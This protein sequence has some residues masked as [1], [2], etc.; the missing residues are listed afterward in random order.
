MISVRE[1]ANAFIFFSLKAGDEPCTNM[2]LNKLLYFAQGYALQRFGE[3]LFDAEFEA[4]DFGPVLPEVYHKYKYCGDNPIAAM[5]DG[6]SPDDLA[7]DIQGLL[8]DVSLV[9]EQYST[10]A[11]VGMSHK[12]GSPWSAVERG[13]KIPTSAIADWFASRE[14][15]LVTMDARLAALPPAV[16]AFL[17][18]WPGEWHD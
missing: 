5:D 16:P 13:G 17:D 4:W 14:P 10:S 15:K 6:L 7:P 1:A 11:L 3:P 12:K 18:D 2:R 8:I 9:M